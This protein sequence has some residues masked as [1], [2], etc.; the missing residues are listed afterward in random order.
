MAWNLTLQDASFRG[1]AFEVEAVEDRGENALVVHEYPFRPGA[2]VENMGRKARVIPVTALFWGVAYEAKVKALVAAFEEDGPGELIHP[3]F[4]SCNVMVRN[5]RIRHSAER[6][7]YAEVP[8]EAVEAAA[9]NPFFGA[10]S[11]RSLAEQALD[12]VTSGLAEAL[13]LAESELGR[14][15]A[16]WAEAAA[17]VKARVELELQGVLNV[18][19]AG[20]E[21][22]RSVLSY[23]DMP[24][25]FLADARAIV[26]GARADAQSAA[27]SVTAAF[28]T[29]SNALP[30]PSLTTDTAARRYAVGA[31]AYG[32]VWVSGPQSALAGRAEARRAL[33]LP[34]PAPVADTPP[35]AGSARTPRGQA[36]L[37]V[38]LIGLAELA[39]AVATALK[40][41]MAAPCLTPNEIESLAGNVR[42]RLDDALHYAA[43]ALPSGAVH[44]VTDNLRTTARGVWQLAEAALNARP[45]LVCHVTDRPCNFHALAHRLY[46]DYARADELRR[47]NPQVKHPN[48]IAKGQ[49]LLIYAR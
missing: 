10:A 43:A 2:E 34:R 11:S 5:W 14:T 23:V 26:R 17:N 16:Q 18:L 25:A 37:C 8:F 33:R 4:G 45:P 44:A 27:S 15:L 20:R 28:S 9:D 1:V 39:D 47:I 31:A 30:L 21:S 35:A 29:L 22:L 7:D 42:A 6:H 46:G 40:A 13:G 36:V 41:D 12:A 3:V 48:F 38:I 19:D 32:P 24:A 49:E